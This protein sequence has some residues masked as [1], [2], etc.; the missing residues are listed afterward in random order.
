MS[1]FLYFD[2]TYL[3]CMLPAILA[4]MAAQIFVSS[5]YR[6]W[7][8]VAAS[9]RLTGAQAAQRLIQ[10]KNLYDVEV[11]GIRGNLTD[12][13]DPNRK[14]LRLSE[15]VYGQPS[16]ASIAIAA[17][18]LGHALQDAEGY[19][20]LRLRAA[21]VPVVNIGSYLGWIFIFVGLLLNFTGLALAGVFIFGFGALFALIT[22]PVEFDASARAKRMLA[23]SGIISVDEQRGVNAVLNAAALTYVA[24]LFAAIMQLLYYASLV[25]GGRRR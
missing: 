1:P 6:K 14:V 23:E 25:L 24:S 17:H 7:S 5:A 15:K 16:V 4:T 19:G 9:S 20:P 21:L 2:P 18:E 22:L 8:K 10:H 3:M 12:H 11:Q 13:Y